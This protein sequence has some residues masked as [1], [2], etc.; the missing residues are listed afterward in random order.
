AGRDPHDRALR[1]LIGELSTLSTEFRTLWARHD[2]RVHHHGVKRLRHPEVGEVEL[3]YR[4]M[5]L[6][7]SNRTAHDLTVY[8]A[9]PGSAAEDRLRLLASWAATG[10][11]AT[12][13]TQ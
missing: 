12:E 7:A 6:P 13:P 9:E 2:V 4:T 1:E 3:T 8:T 11:P 10:S 5:N